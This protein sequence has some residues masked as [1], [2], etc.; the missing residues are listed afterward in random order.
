MLRQAWDEFWF[1]LDEGWG[2]G[3]ALGNAWD[4]IKNWEKKDHED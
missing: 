3:V 4:T 1:A 2:L